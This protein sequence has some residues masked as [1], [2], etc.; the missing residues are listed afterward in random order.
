MRVR[1]EIIY[2]GEADWIEKTLERSILKRRGSR[3]VT[4]FGTIKLMSEVRGEENGNKPVR[5]GKAKSR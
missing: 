5:K 1:R 2:E 4:P 3:F